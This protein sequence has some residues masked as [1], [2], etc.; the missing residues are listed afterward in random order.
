MGK[1][2][3]K[4]NFMKYEIF[5]NILVIFLLLL[6]SK[7]YNNSLNIIIASMYTL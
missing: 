6:L 7:I 3:V 2:F 5:V 4:C 1:W